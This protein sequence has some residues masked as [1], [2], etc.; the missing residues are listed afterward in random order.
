MTVIPK[1]GD[2]RTLAASANE[3]KQTIAAFEIGKTDLLK[4]SARGSAAGFAHADSI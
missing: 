3:K 4:H 2:A 1:R